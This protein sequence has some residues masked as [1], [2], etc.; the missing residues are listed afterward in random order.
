MRMVSSVIAAAFMVQA[1][2]AEN[3]IVTP[4][5]NGKT[6]TISLK[7]CVDVRLKG[8]GG[9]T[10]FEWHLGTDT[11]A[12]PYLEM[13]ELTTSYTKSPATSPY[14]DIVLCAVKPGKGVVTLNY[15]PMEK[16]TSPMETLTFT[17]VVKP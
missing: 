7:Q 13:H 4:A 11:R 12:A 16:Q 1:A 5:D 3:V 10:G 6:F 17:V 2:W 8:R 15:R 14:D 9:S